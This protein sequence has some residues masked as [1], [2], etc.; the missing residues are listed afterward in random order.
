MK[1]YKIRL[2]GAERDWVM[3]SG[4]LAVPEKFSGTR[5]QLGYGAAGSYLHTTE[6]DIPKLVEAIPKYERATPYGGPMA[7]SVA[8]KLKKRSSSSSS[9]SAKWRAGE[10]TSEGRRLYYVEILP[11]SAFPHVSRQFAYDTKA[12]RDRA[13]A[14][15]KSPT[16]KNALALAKDYLRANPRLKSD[17]ARANRY[18]AQ[19]PG[20][21]AR[22]FQRHYPDSRKKFATLTA[23]DVAAARKGKASKSK[24]KSKRAPK[25]IRVM[26]GERDKLAIETLDVDARRLFTVD[27][28]AMVFQAKNRAAISKAINSYVRAE[29][30][31]GLDYAEACRLKAIARKVRTKGL[32]K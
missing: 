21:I 13:V 7:R 6:N 31:H 20:D 1:K 9:S 29:K 28:P 11:T 26:V 32:K 23:A 12:E 19:E 25:M 4:I 18:A 15:L 10:R 27:G 8:A 17:P 30:R 16:K 3:D 2:T 5:L 24:A 14:Y 22:T